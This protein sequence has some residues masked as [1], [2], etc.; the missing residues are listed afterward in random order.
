MAA[1]YSDDSKTDSDYEVLGAWHLAREFFTYS[2]LPGH[3][4]DNPVIIFSDEDGVNQRDSENNPIQTNEAFRST[5]QTSDRRPNSEGN[6]IMGERYEESSRH[7]PTIERS[8]CDNDDVG[9]GT[10]WYGE[11]RHE[12]NNWNGDVYA[13]RRGSR[14]LLRPGSIYTAS[15]GGVLYVRGRQG[16]LEDGEHQGVSGQIREV[17]ASPSR[18]TRL[19]N[20]RR[21]R[22]PCLPDSDWLQRPST[23]EWTI[24]GR[25]EE[26]D[27]E[28][29]T[30]LQEFFQAAYE[31]DTEDW[32]AI[33]NQREEENQEYEMAL[34]AT[35]DWDEETEDESNQTVWSPF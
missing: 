8:R 22:S 23:R 5:G 2:N 17:S 3:S 11:R 10:V 34:Q 27:T 32:Q 9:A 20:G 4:R 18:R 12:R 15:P 24:L 26:V 21:S 14:G 28:T 16:L 25:E 13:S 31:A 7:S 30:F 1:Y 35:Q 33:Y 19:E 6:E 29:Q